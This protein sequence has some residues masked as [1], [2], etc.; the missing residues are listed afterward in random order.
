MRTETMYQWRA[1]CTNRDHPHYLRWIR[2]W[3]RQARRRQH[4]FRKARERTE[5]GCVGARSRAPTRKPR[6]DG[7]ATSLVS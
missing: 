2:W 1:P 7:E 6:K 4:L 3:N 5:T